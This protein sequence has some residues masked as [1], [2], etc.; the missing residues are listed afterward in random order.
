MTELP[1]GGANKAIK[2]KKPKK[3]AADDT[4]KVITKEEKAKAKA[5]KAKIK[6]E[7][8]GKVTEAKA[9]TKAEKAK[10]MKR[11]QR[12]E[13]L[14]EDIEAYKKALKSVLGNQF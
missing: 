8:E 5:E 9:A 13:K 7:G 6:E 1:K 3:S 14:A 10:I 2:E 12:Q 11:R 4:A